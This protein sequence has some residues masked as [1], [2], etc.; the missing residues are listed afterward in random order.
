MTSIT[1]FHIDR[2]EKGLLT[3]KRRFLGFWTSRQR[4]IYSSFR[5]IRNAAGLPQFRIYD[6]RVNAITRLLSDPNVSPQVSKEI[7]GHISQRM[8]DRY[9]IQLFS[10]KKRA[11]D[12][13]ND[14]PAPVPTEPKGRVIAF[15]RG[16]GRA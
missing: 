5:N 8:Q 14:K 3:G 15:R 10:T 2:G 7:A 13:L 12:G 9:S 16:G 6:C 11:L 4:A 1:F